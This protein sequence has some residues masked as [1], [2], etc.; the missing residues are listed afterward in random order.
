VHH[1]KLPL[2]PSYYM[3]K[4]VISSLIHIDPTIA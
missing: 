2:N 4:T 1:H 3:N